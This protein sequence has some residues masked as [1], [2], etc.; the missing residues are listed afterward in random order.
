M[1]PAGLTSPPPAPGADDDG[2]VPPHP[3]AASMAP[4]MST[5][6]RWRLIGGTLAP[7]GQ[8]L[9]RVGSTPGQNP[10]VTPRRAGTFAC[11]TAAG[12]LLVE[13]DQAIPPGLMRLLAS[14]GDDVRRLPRA[15][16]ALA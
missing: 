16:P 2:D 8:G 4:A 14:Q 1:S 10:A 13:D 6:A 12:I 15:R 11:V 9:A 3:A 5:P 7:P